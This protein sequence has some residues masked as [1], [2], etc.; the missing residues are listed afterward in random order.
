MHPFGISTRCSR[1]TLVSLV[2]LPPA[3]GAVADA[4]AVRPT[5]VALA[6]SGGGARGLAHIGALRALE[7]AGIPIDAVAANSVGAVVGGIFATGRS[8][9]ELEAIVR[10]LDWASLF[11][12]RPDRR[13]LPISRR[14]DRYGALV[15]VSF[16]WK[17]VR[18]PAGLVA[19]HRVNRFLIENLAPAAFAAGGDFDRL[20]IRF[21]AVAT[22]LADGEPVVLERGDL[23]HAVR[24]SMSVPLAFP[25]VDWGGR[26]LV[27]GLVVDNLPIDL[28][29]GWKPAVLVA[30]DA[31][32]PDLEPS[33]YDSALGVASRINDL[34]TSRRNR[35]FHAEA[36][37]QVRPDLGRHSST[38]YSGLD[39]L[40]RRGYEATRAAL[41][42]IREKLL[43]AGV[44]DM[45]R[46]PQPIAG[47]PLQGAAIREVAVRGN[48]RLED[49]LILRTFNIPAGAGYDMD[50][51][52]RAFDKITGTGLLERTWIEFE[53]EGDGVRVVLRVKEAPENRAQVAVGYS[54]WE[55]SR[56]A[57]RLLNRNTLG[58]GEQVELLLA[59]SDAESLARLSLTSDRLLLGGLGYA[60]R[61]DA[62]TDKPRFFDADGNEI[63]RASFE[64]TGV[65]LALRSPLKRWLEVE[66]GFRLGR[67]NT[68]AEA[69]IELPVTS[70]HVRA[71][72]AS[73][74]YDTLDSLA[75]PSD[76]KRLALRA[77]WSPAGLGPS[78]E[79][80][81]FEVRGRLGHALGARSVVQLDG[82]VGL[83]GR[84][85]PVYDWQRLGGV[86]LLPG[87]CHEQLKGAQA[88]AAAASLRYRIAGDLR[89]VA[90]A[91]AGNVFA[92]SS[93]IRLAGSHWGA[94]IGA[95]LPT[96]V[97]P[98]SAELAVHDGGGTLVAFALGWD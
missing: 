65:E 62:I 72:F 40:I 29:R 38:D 33:E 96:R 58:F 54:E 43:G 44:S 48:L 2:L 8:A 35:D 23:A 81:M 22:D 86:E 94:A 16:D 42:Q 69:G 30:I 74:T 55:R 90:R 57:V 56:A 24:A 59:A 20:P 73:A 80:W 97:G 15:G 12:G 9:Q 91:G 71:V 70:D 50:K 77:V 7:E 53:P 64:R 63:N 76:G 18:F 11:S 67:V 52:L 88:L 61:A 39:E 28:A 31:T 83:S 14:H 51:G 95:M 47:R 93:D 84:D 75:W 66:G 85:L 26:R 41:P 49:R 10:S 87:Y 78:H 45:G 3:C 32:S 19:E 6:L 98:V 1:L 46:H 5:R 27:D 68:R 13:T 21:R 79:Y 37:V 34:L 82:L 4:Q 89:L 17:H 25:P 60:V 92:R 36:D